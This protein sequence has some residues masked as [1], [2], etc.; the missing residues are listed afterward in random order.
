MK[1]PG[2][3]LILFL[4]SS[5]LFA[6][7]YSFKENKGQFPGKDTV[8]YYAHGNGFWITFHKAKLQ[9]HYESR[10]RRSDNG[11]LEIILSSSF[12]SPV[13]SGISPF[14]FKENF[15]LAGRP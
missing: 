2:L 6:A 11:V 8:L 14:A 13:P 3:N 5:S 4:V 10:Q 15:Y 7:D 1:F 12:S 9:I